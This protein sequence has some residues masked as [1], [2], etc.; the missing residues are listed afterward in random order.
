MLRK[1]RQ[2]SETFGISLFYIPIYN[3]YTV[4]T[5]VSRNYSVRLTVYVGD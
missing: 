1:I 5:F 4:L 3:Y 2:I